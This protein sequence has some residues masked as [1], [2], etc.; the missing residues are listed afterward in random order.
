MA[1]YLM[2]SVSEY[3]R[4]S[5]GLRL[6]R[7]HVLPPVAVVSDFWSLLLHPEEGLQGSEAATHDDSILLGSP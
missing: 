6:T 1:I 7:I 4:P 2:V 5:E 3:L